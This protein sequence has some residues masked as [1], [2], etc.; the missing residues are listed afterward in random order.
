M[1]RK[2]APLLL[3]LVVAPAFAQPSVVG[4][5]SGKLAA[6]KLPDNAPA[7]AMTISP[8]FN[9]ELKAD[10]TYIWKM[11]LEMPSGVTFNVKSKGLEPEPGTYKLEKGKLILTPKDKERK[12]RTLTLSA[13]GKS[14][15]MTMTARARTVNGPDDSKVKDAGKRTLTL[16]RVK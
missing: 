3:T 13:D 4:K 15:S 12:G 9:L 6:P 1:L 8:Q 16:N 10:G 14:L 2:L 5:W 11:E 7:G